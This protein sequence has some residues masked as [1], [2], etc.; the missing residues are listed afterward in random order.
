VKMP[1]NEVPICHGILATHRGGA[2]TLW[3]S[4][5]STS[6]VW[7]LVLSVDSGQIERGKEEGQRA[8]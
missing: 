4:K 6:L 7:V 1:W 8:I 2:S 5:T 3:A